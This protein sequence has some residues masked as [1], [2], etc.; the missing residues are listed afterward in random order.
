MRAEA[1]LRKE[2]TY[3]GQDECEGGSETGGGELVEEQCIGGPEAF[4][5]SERQQRQ[6]RSRREKAAFFFRACV[7]QRGSCV[8]QNNSTA[9]RRFGGSPF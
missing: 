1:N 6:P 7:S 4:P 2:S 5:K 8:F 3:E 9:A